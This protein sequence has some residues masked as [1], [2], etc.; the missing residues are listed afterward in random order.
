M[1]SEQNLST[2]NKVTLKY[3]DMQTHQPRIGFSCCYRETPLKEI[4]SRITQVLHFSLSAS[5]K[6]STE[7]N[8]QKCRVN[9]FFLPSGICRTFRKHFINQHKTINRAK[10]QNR[11]AKVYWICQAEFVARSAMLFI[12]S[13]STFF[14]KKSFNHKKSHLKSEGAFT[15]NVWQ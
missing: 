1:I 11:H 14:K 2:W 13:L 5:T 15:G 8:T 7:L 10:M 12:I 3:W 4:M 9:I 6:L